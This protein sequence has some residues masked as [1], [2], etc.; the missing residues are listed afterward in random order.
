MLVIICCPN[1][2]ADALQLVFLLL[3]FARALVV[4]FFVRA[5][6]VASSRALVVA[7]IIVLMLLSSC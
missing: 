3:S 5:L 4:A 7:L 6:V 2:H 1:D